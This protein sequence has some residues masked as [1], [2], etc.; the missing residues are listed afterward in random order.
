MHMLMGQ[1]VSV[2]LSV[3]LV[4]LDCIKTAPYAPEKFN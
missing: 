3:D 2:M 1:A 4:N